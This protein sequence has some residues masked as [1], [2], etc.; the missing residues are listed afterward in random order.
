MRMEIRLPEMGI[1]LMTVLN[2]CTYEVPHSILV[3]SFLLSV[4]ERVHK[5]ELHE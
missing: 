5:I 1:Q 2:I 4:K 3:S